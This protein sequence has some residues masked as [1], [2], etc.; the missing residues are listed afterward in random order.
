[1]A[2]VAIAVILLV[3]AGLFAGSFIQLIRIDPG[4]DYK[5]LLTFSVSTCTNFTGQL[6]PE[7][8]EESSKQ[9]RWFSIGC[10][11]PLDRPRHRVRH[12]GQEVFL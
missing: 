5:N 6:T 7:Q 8:R 3:G 12:D 4:F 11:R 1:M 10:S 9:S 2:E